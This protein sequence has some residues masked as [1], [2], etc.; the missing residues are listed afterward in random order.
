[1]HQI[2]QAAHAEMKGK[3]LRRSVNALDKFKTNIN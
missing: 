2:K 3:L 1:M